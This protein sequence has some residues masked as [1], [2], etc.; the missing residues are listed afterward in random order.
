[1]S[2]EPIAFSS[3]YAEARDRF[4]EAAKA[5]GGRLEAYPI[6]A[7]GPG[8]SDLAIDVALVGGPPDPERVVVVSSG[9]HGVEGF[10]GSAI[11]LA[12]LQAGGRSQLPAGLRLVLVHGANP[13]GFAWRRR[14]DDTIST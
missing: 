12:W 7:K 1:M 11:Q 5:A 3:D 6:D 9:L 10:F 13:Y 2:T 14:W 8:N 4:R